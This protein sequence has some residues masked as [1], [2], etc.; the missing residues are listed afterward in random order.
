VR[1]SIDSDVEVML[2]PD[3]DEGLSPIP[4]R[5]ASEPTAHRTLTQRAAVAQSQRWLTAPASMRSSLYH[6]A[7]DSSFELD[8]KQI[9]FSRGRGE[10]AA[11]GIYSS[12]FR[13]MNIAVV[14]RSERA[15]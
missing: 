1:F 11:H 8:C 15:K 9:G 3:E 13:L 6:Y 14:L 5:L 12:K 2:E 4:D 7:L 10:G